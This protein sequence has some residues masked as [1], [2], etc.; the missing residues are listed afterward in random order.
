LT[1]FGL[2]FEGK[3]AKENDDLCLE[4]SG[5]NYMTECQ[6]RK[7]SGNIETIYIIEKLGRMLW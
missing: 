7:L 3:G 4:K 1:Q 5:E 6:L 2:P